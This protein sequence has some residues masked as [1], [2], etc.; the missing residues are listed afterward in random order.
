[1]I[2][3]PKGVAAIGHVLVDGIGRATEAFIE[4]FGGLPS[5]AHVD[6]SLMEE[7]CASLGFPGSAWTEAGPAASGAVGAAPAPAEVSWRAGG[8]AA[9]LTRAAS[10][11]GVPAEVWGSLGRDGRGAFLAKELAAAGVGVHLIESEKPT[12]IFCRLSSADGKRIV[13]STGAARDIRGV[14]IPESAFRQG[15]AFHIDGLLIDSPEWLATQTAKAKSAGMLIAMDLSIPTNA[16]SYASA[17]L[18]F[19]NTYC[20]IVFANEEE[21]RAVGGLPPASPPSESATAP[22][23]KWVVKR[24]KRGA[25]LWDGLRWIEVSAVRDIEP[26]DDTGA[27]D[28]FAAGFL[29]ATLEGRSDEDCLRAG[30]AVASAAM[31]GRGHIYGPGILKMALER[32]KADSD[33][34]VK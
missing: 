29:S 24:G 32:A 9:I 20:D 11:L 34:I 10:A 15:W 2:F 23:P 33:R 30:N 3:R 28:I 6:P 4:R 12:G 7:L 31:G 26:A 1:M 17:L 22:S 13:V 25:A 21:Y 14:E 8:G 5:P 18:V 19:V 27:G 16:R